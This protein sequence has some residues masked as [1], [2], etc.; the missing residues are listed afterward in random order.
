MTNASRAHGRRDTH[1]HVIVCGNEKSGSGKST[2]AM[3]VAVAL[4]KRGFR[5]ATVD[6][7]SRQLS[8]TRYV[9]NRRN[10]SR[11]TRRNLEMPHHFHVP[12]AVRPS[13]SDAEAVEFALLSGGLEEVEDDH[14][15]VVIDTPGADTYLARLAHMMADTLI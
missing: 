12:K 4:L 15:F 9:E 2:I 13:T 6:L 11:S 7:D 3:H 14:D 1:A 5:V 8:F 10:W